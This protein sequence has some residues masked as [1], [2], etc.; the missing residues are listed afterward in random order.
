[1]VQSGKPEALV[2]SSVLDET[3]PPLHESLNA[4][5]EAKRQSLHA[6]ELVLFS[7]AVVIDD[8]LVSLLTPSATNWLDAR[9]QFL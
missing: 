4:V 1:M 8:R 6:F 3:S 5:V 7:V 2:L 9:S